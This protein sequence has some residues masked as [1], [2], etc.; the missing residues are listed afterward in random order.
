MDAENPITLLGRVNFRNDRRLFGIKRADRRAHLY[1][2]GKTGTGKSTLLET[3]IRQDLERGEGLALFDPHGDL[4][5]QIL[6]SFPE[7]R[8]ADLLYLNVPDIAQ[9]F[10][11]N[12]LERIPPAK[13]SVAAANLVEVF[14]KIWA[15]SWGPRLEYLLRNA[16]FV[17][18]D[19]PEP[20]LGDVPRLL[21]E[22]EFR[23]TAAFRTGNEEV[24]RF[25]LQEYESYPK[26]FKA[27]V[28]A[29]LENKVGAFLADPIL[30]RILTSPK[31]SFDLRRVMDEGKVLLVNLAKGRIGEGPAALL[32][33]L[34]VSS[35]GLTGLARAEVAEENRRDFYVYLDEFQ[36]FT[37]L[38]LAS[39]LS[40]LRKYR[41]SMTLTNQ[42]LGQVDEEVRDAVLGNVG[43][44][45]AFRVGGEDARIL[46]REFLPEFSAEDLASLPNYSIYLK[47]MV[48][49][50]VTRG[51]S[52]QTAIGIG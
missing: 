38:S 39:M 34:L 43:T 4:V 14:R 2:I 24:R 17:L 46:E 27:E 52:G 8:R 47:L 11:F 28:I 13:R 7:R 36:T 26:T 41:V 29:P 40:E 5:E 42:Y 25:W 37:T 50:V 1:A 19:Q 22:P 21:H 12:P 45:V 3:M 31:S 51:F 20:T 18:L 30:N 49:G 6:E 35:I 23:K 15:D 48:N 44:L 16:L 9:L 33:S 10:R 32:G